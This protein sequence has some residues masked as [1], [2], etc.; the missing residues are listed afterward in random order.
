MTTFSPTR[1]QRRCCN[2]PD[3]P[4]KIG[5]DC[6]I[7]QAVIA[8]HESRPDEDSAVPQFR[9]KKDIFLVIHIFSASAAVAELD[10]AFARRAKAYF[11]VFAVDILHIGGAVCPAELKHHILVAVRTVSVSD[12]VFAVREEIAASQQDAVVNP[13]RDLFRQTVDRLGK[14]HFPRVLI[15]LVGDFLRFL[16]HVATSQQ[17]RKVKADDVVGLRLFGDSVIFADPRVDRFV[18]D[19]RAAVLGMLSCFSCH[20]FHTVR[21]ALFPIRDLARTDIVGYKRID[22]IL[23]YVLLIRAALFALG[24]DFGYCLFHQFCHFFHFSFK[25]C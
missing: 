13:L 3:I 14:S 22:D 24:V 11:L 4:Q 18:F 9:G 5:L 15:L 8:L 23:R 10:R 21:K 1:R 2:R 7:V 25:S 17:I 12:A 6:C 20:G 19:H 16:S